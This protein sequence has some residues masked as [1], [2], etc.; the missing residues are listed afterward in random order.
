MCALYGLICTHTI[1]KQHVHVYIES[2]QRQTQ[3]YWFAIC[4]VWFRVAPRDL[5]GSDFMFVWPCG[6]CIVKS[7]CYIGRWFGKL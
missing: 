2:A 1:I 4:A 7:E 3:R 6:T 5:Y